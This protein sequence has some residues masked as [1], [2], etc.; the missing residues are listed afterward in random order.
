M[1]KQNSFSFAGTEIVAYLIFHNLTC[2][3]KQQGGTEVTSQHTKTL[4]LHLKL[5]T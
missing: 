1:Y 5:K 4:G 2:I 3:I